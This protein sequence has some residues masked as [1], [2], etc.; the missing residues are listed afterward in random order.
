MC[1]V[2]LN[3]SFHVSSNIA[4]LNRCKVTKVADVQNFSNMSQKLP[5][6]RFY[7]K[8]S[9][10]QNLSV[11]G[12]FYAFTVCH[13][14]VH[15]SLCPLG[16]SVASLSPF[17]KWLWLNDC[18]SVIFQLYQFTQAFSKSYIHRSR[19]EIRIFQA[20][21]P[22]STRSILMSRKITNANSV[23]ILS[24]DPPS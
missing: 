1:V 11:F 17:I 20:K 19:S 5:P 10:F 22:K 21:W 3:V 12:D 16:F 6:A 23:A 15:V 7:S 4:Y 2:F 14:I 24:T 18:F 8:S 13:E 9:D